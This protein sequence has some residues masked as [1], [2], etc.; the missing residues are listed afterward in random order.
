MHYIRFLK[1]PSIRIPQ[2]S[3]KRGSDGT[4]KATASVHALVTIE[5][6][7]GDSIF[8]GDADL[9]CAVLS[10]T[11]KDSVVSSTGAKSNGRQPH[12]HFILGTINVAW[13]GGLRS[14]A[15]EVPLTGVDVKALTAL[16]LRLCVTANGSTGHAVAGKGLEWV[17]TNSDYLV[18][19]VVIAQTSGTITMKDAAAA[20][21]VQVERP[22]SLGR[23]RELVIWEDAGISM[24]R[25]VW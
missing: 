2:P 14:L 1:Q 5:T 22:L 19:P 15:V 8:F 17:D 11:A 24:A 18:M 16:K 13:T 12:P 10:V 23:G 3:K 25:H 21:R 9:T 20:G 7:L 6:D 4:A